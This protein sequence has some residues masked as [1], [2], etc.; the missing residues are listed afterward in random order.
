MVLDESEVKKMAQLAK[1]YISDSD[2]NE[3]GHR[4][5]EILTLVDQMQ[6]VDTDLVEPLYHPLDAVQ[7]LRPDVVTERNQRDELQNLAPKA[8]MGL[9]LVPQVLD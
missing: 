1:L 4:I 8:E 9:Y 2:I 7:K 5:T 3:I 6:S